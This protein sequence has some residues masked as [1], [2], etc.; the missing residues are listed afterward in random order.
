MTNATQKT[1]NFAT[2]VCVI[3]FL[4]AYISW[5]LGYSYFRIPDIT[6]PVLDNFIIN[7][8][9]SMILFQ[10]NIFFM[11]I[12]VF[13]KPSNKKELL[14]G[15]IMIPFC[16]VVLIFP[17]FAIIVSIIIPFI[18]FIIICICKKSFKKYF[19]KFILFVIIT[20]LYNHLATQIKIS[21][22]DIFTNQLNTI[23]I[24]MYSID[25]FIFYTFLYNNIQ[26]RYIHYDS[27]ENLVR[28][29]TKPHQTQIA[30][31]DDIENIDFSKYNIF[32][33]IYIISYVVVIQL[34]QLALVLCVGVI[35]GTFYEML[36]LIPTFIILRTF[37]LK[38]TIHA[39]NM[40]YCTILTALV[41]YSIAKISPP[42]HISLFTGIALTSL[43]VLIL[44]YIATNT[45]DIYSMSESELRLHCQKHK[46]TENMQ[47]YV[48]GKVIEGLKGNALACYVG[49]GIHSLEYYSKTTRKLLHINNW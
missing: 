30:S 10:I 2:V 28:Q 37:I 5:V 23:N 14:L 33:R 16:L 27:M 3:L 42:L 35:S 38:Q 40:V 19:W 31:P 4:T 13:G 48:I 44:H 18:F 26:R 11:Q 47:Q 41:F 9:V 43:F 32:E 49:C 45:I 6:I 17:E 46:I 20:I 36:I 29:L 24:I 39:K 25:L 34:L 15:L 8:L 22:P 21:M 1:I 12:I 7:G